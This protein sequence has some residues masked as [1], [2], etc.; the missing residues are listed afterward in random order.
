[1]VKRTRQQRGDGGEEEGAEV[2]VPDQPPPSLL[3][4]V[5]RTSPTAQPAAARARSGRW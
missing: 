5:Q 1:L 2:P 4:R 3:A